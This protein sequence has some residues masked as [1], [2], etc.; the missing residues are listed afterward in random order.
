MITMR[1]L[2]PIALSNPIISNKAVIKFQLKVFINNNTNYGKENYFIRV[3][4]YDFRVRHDRDYMFYLFL[5]L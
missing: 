5:H 2:H 3:N 1:L 4:P